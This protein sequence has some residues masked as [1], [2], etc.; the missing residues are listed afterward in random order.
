MQTEADVDRA[1]ALGADR[2]RAVVCGNTKFDQAILS[3]PPAEQE[4]LRR[5]FGLRGEQPLWIA[6]ST[7][8]G[9]EEQVLAAWRGVRSELPDLAL[10]IAPRHIER[11]DDVE[12]LCRQAAPGHPII[13]RSQQ[14]GSGQCDRPSG[15]R[16][17]ACTLGSG[18]RREAALAQSGRPAPLYPEPRAQSPELEAEPT[19]PPII[20]LDTLGELAGMY[21]LASVV[22][23]GGSLVPVGGHDI[24]QPLFHGKPTFFGPHMHNQRD[25][26][27]LSVNAGACTRVADSEALATSV[28]AVLT[29]PARRASMARSARSLLGAHRGAAERCA[30]M[31]LGLLPEGAQPRAYDQQSG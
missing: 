16:E 21:A 19:L 1:V 8:P 5:E 6:G 28:R 12:A 2:Q 26:A 22:F 14:D 25:L 11:A 18:R 30:Q 4:A 7:H 3:P 17:R 13:R 27:Q 31:V 10:M 24:L 23:V 9:E 29:D 15:A 20:V